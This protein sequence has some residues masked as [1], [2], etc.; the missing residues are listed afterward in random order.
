MLILALAAGRMGIFYWHS[1]NDH[2]Y[3]NDEYFKLLGY[4]PGEVVPGFAAWMARI[5]PEDRSRLAEIIKS[6]Q[7]EYT[8]EFRVMGHNGAVHW[9]EAY[10]RCELDQA[11]EPCR[12]YA[13]MFDITARKMAEARSEIL[14]KEV[15]HRAKNL[16][17]VVQ[18][19]AQLTQLDVEPEEFFETFSDRLEG[20]AASHTLIVEAEWKGV[21]L[22]T[23][24]RAQLH[25]LG[26]LID[27]RILLDG[28][29]CTL[30]AAAAQ[31]LGMALHELSTNAVKYGALTNRD[32]IVLL[33]WE[34]ATESP[35]GK[36]YF[37]M[38]WTEEGGPPVVNPTRKGFGHTVI[39]ELPEHLL[40]ATV[41][42]TFQRQG[43]EWKLEAP[44]AKV[45][46]KPQSDLES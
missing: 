44:A 41:S 38:S 32:G 31:A 19:I 26:D 45:I 35:E 43:A 8:T 1:K 29:L 15:N 34:Q 6:A 42:Y 33:S 28:S 30:T 4:K 12:R 3:W 5:V 22:E 11:G 16:L 14:L 23:L 21:D 46:Q 24:V 13:V 40:S 25:H 18:S 36:P 20:L 27:R 39:V 17:T 2:A 9:L 10:G 7:P 37:R